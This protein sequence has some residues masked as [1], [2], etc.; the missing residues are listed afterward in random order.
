LMLFQP[1]VTDETDRGVFD[2][3]QYIL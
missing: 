1:F 3:G 2:G